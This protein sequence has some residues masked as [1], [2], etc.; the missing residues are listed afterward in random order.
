MLPDYAKSIIELA[1]KDTR[2][3]LKNNDTNLS[4]IGLC[5]KH[6]DTE[7]SEIGLGFRIKRADPV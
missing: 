5:F 4:Y 1:S 6:N 2:L 7:P 3:C